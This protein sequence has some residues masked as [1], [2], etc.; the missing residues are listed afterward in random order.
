MCAHE[1]TYVCIDF[2]SCKLDKFTS[3]FL[4]AFCILFEIMYTDNRVVIEKHRF[5]FSFQSVFFFNFLSCFIIKART[6]IVMLNRTDGRELIALS[7]TLEGHQCVFDNA[8]VSC[9]FL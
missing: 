5:L 1:H 6:L 4:K 9:N 7:L 2:L 8:D 3:W